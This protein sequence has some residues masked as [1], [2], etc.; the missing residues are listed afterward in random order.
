MKSETLIL[1]AA[2]VGMGLLVSQAVS[3]STAQA[4]ASNQ[5]LAAAIKESGRKSSLSDEVR[6]WTT[7]VSGILDALVGGI[8]TVAGLFN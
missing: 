7:T 6:E 3:A 8:G 4:A 1:G 5:A 2:V